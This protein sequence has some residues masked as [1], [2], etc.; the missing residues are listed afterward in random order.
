MRLRSPFYT[1]NLGTDQPYNS[2]ML[3]C[4]H[5]DFTCPGCQNVHLAK[6]PL[7]DF[8]I[9]ELAD[10]IA[11]QLICDEGLTIGGLEFTKSGEGFIQ[12]L[13]RL[14]ESA[15]VKNLTIYTREEIDHDY[16][17]EAIKV[18]K[19]VVDHLYIKTGRYIAGA[20][21]KLVTLGDFQI[22]LAS[23]NQNY[24]EIN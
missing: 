1:E 13:A 4:P 6:E 2:L 3:L 15:S 7:T 20:P 19:P 23:D 11:S 17:V 9:E 14:C 21:S 16:I 12:E 22:T 24:A 10:L 5:C 8:S 18:L